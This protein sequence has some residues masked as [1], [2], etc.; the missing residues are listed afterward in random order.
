ML[1]L[2]TF[3]FTVTPPSHLDNMLA[4]VETVYRVK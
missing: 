4:T 1:P 2:T 3:P